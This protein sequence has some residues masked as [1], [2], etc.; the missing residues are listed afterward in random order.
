[1]LIFENS[2]YD[3]VICIWNAANVTLLYKSAKLFLSYLLFRIILN[4]ITL[5]ALL[6]KTN[7]GSTDGL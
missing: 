1:L 4:N 6:K 7:A 5:P 3:I 2:A